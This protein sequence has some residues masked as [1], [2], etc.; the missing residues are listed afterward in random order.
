MTAPEKEAGDSQL[1]TGQIQAR[2][3]PLLACRL[4]EKE[5]GQFAVVI[6]SELATVGS[7]KDM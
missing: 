5:K 1:L 2:Y 3:K 6:Q 7:T 4:Y